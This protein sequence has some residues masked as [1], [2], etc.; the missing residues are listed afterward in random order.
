MAVDP[1]D[2]QPHGNVAVDDAVVDEWVFAAWSPD[3][4]LG[5]VSGHRLFGRR[6]WYWAALAELGGPVLHVT[7]FDVR[8]R[9]ADPFIVKAEVLWAEH[10]C[11]APLE[12][13]TIGNE[14][15][16]A[17]LDDPDDALGRAYGAPTSIAFD[18]EWYAVGAATGIGA[19]DVQ[20]YEQPGVVHG[21]VEVSGRPGI[22]LVEVPAHRWHR[23]G[24]GPLPP[25]PLP[26]ALA[27]TGVRVP[28]RFPDG[29]V[30]DL[31]LTREGWRR[32]AT[33]LPV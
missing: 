31:V 24:S 26:T 8:V 10:T 27:H 30:C 2:E 33:R 23:W 20:G 4:R 12:Q 5:V 9:A 17:A 3:G 29:T 28:F 14:T 7:E 25:L 18:L 16:A 13:W 1:R 21:V 22:E 15:Y 32:R 19:G 11:E 6:A